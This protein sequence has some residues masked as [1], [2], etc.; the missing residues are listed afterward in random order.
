[1]PH[2]PRS[3]AVIIVNYGTAD[4]TIQAVDSVLAQ[5]QGAGAKGYEAQVHLVDNAS[6]SGDAAVLSQAHADKGWGARVSLYLETENHGFGRG[7]NVVLDRLAAQG[8]P[9]D[10]VF[11]LNPDAQL[12]NDVLSILLARAEADARVGMAGAGISLPGGSPVTA[13]FRF[14]SARADFAHAV[15]FGPISR[16]FK[17]AEV[18]L[19]PDQPEGPV[20]WVAGAAVLMRFSMLQEIGFFDPVFFLYYEEVELMHRARQAGWT[21][22]YVPQARVIHAEG[23]A[24]DQKSSRTERRA[25]PAYWYDSWRYYHAKTHGRGGAILSGLAWMTGAGLNYV[26]APLRGQAPKAPRNFYPDFWRHVM[27]PLITGAPHG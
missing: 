2:T 19:P 17:T 18:A 8:T 13:A 12:E 4:L 21:I 7:N 23:A 5:Q 22:L 6:P 3:I 14:P 24:T 10:Y 11:L 1:M 25:K 26:I 16:L 15:N 9:P 20:D 27:R